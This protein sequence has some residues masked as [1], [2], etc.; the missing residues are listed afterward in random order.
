LDW[1]TNG[2]AEAFATPDGRLFYALLI[3]SDVVSPWVKLVCDST[4]RVDKILAGDDGGIELARL[5]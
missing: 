4:G 3:F 5:D 2:I 1:P